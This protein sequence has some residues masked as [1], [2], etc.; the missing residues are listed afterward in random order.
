MT[1]LKRD[2]AH[3]TTPIEAAALG[4][5]HYQGK[6]YI[7]VPSSSKATPHYVE[8]DAGGAVL[9]CDER[10]EDWNY[11]GKERGEPCRHM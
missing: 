6:R 2:A 9:C 11:R 7:I 5:A 4:S 8:I 3:H 10:C 1:I